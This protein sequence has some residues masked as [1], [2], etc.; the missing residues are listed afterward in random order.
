MKRI[1]FAILF[2]SAFSFSAMPGVALAKHHHRRHHVTHR[3]VYYRSAP[4]S[5]GA[6]VNGNVG[7]GLGPIHVGVGAGGGIHL[8]AFPPPKD[9][10]SDPAN[11]NPVISDPVSSGPVS[12]NDPP[13]S[14]QPWIER[15]LSVNGHFIVHPSDCDLECYTNTSST[16][17]ESTPAMSSESDNNVAV[18]TG[19]PV[20]CPSADPS[21]ACNLNNTSAVITTAPV[22]FATAPRA[23]ERFALS[24]DTNVNSYYATYAQPRMVTVGGFSVPVSNDRMYFSPLRHRHGASWHV[25][26]QKGVDQTAGF[27]SSPRAGPLPESIGG[28]AYSTISVER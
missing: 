3:V 14:N 13:S 6:D 5:H 7:V 20:L 4:R 23:M 22:F 12:A 9:P 18:S 15:Q 24:P 10:I 21:S 28:S 19:E 25:H 16:S 26:N 8:H 17:D 27:G 2:I 11:N 1:I